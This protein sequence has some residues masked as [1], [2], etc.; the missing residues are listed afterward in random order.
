MRLFSMSANMSANEQVM[1]IAVFASG[2]GSNAENLI[3]YFND[4]PKSPIRVAV[5][6]TNRREAG[7]VE[8][9]RRLGVPVEYIPRAGFADAGHVVGLLDSYGVEAVIL[10][11]F[12]LMIPDYLLLR[13]PDRIINIH[14]SLL[15]RHGGKGMYGRHVH[16]AVVEAGDRETGITIHLVN[17][18]YDKGRILFQASVAVE[19]TDTADDVERK[20]HDLEHTHYPRIIAQTLMEV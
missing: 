13:Y 15:P 20:V 19:R 10:A 3:R 9:A 5:V 8:R 4:N 12:L 18:V 6:V 17:E 16:R 1:N 7:V 2:S 14:P 11:G